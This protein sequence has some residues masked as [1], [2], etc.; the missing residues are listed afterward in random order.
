MTDP[1][2]LLRAAGVAARCRGRRERLSDVGEGLLLRRVFRWGS[3][4]SSMPSWRIP[5][6]PK[7]YH[8]RPPVAR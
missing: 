3:W 7:P 4:I 2:P 1:L 8:A 5:L 6:I